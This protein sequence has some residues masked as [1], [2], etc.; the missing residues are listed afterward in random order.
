MREKRNMTSSFY[1]ESSFELA[2]H[3]EGSWGFP[4]PH[5]ENHYCRLSTH[6]LGWNVK[7]STICI[8]PNVSSTCQNFP[9]RQAEPEAIAPEENM[10]LKTGLILR[11]QNR[12]LKLI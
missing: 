2:D 6:N 8:L 7:V 9:P 12:E 4:W 10:G 5:T 11:L 3:L 1:D